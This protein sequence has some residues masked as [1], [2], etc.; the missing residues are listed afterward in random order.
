MTV[1]ELLH[2]EQT[3]AIV[4]AAI[5]VQRSLGIG[6]LE[7]TYQ[8]ALAI[9]L[10]HVEGARVSVEHPC[11]VKYR[12]VEV[13][14]HR[15][16]LLVRLGGLVLVVECK[17]WHDPDTPL[18]LLAQVGNYVSLAKADVGLLLNFGVRPIGVRRVLP[19]RRVDCV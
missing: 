19:H 8:N 3:G 10:S 18:R 17:H 13:A 5:Q 11:A 4:G 9:E 2:H 1:A 7:R 12:G 14:Q 6:L 15:I 16:D